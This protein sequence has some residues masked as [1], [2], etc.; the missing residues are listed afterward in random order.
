[1]PVDRKT[2]N[3]GILTKN[4]RRLTDRLYRIH[5]E[6][7][8]YAP[9]RDLTPLSVRPYRRLSLLSRRNGTPLRRLNADLQEHCKCGSSQIFVLNFAKGAVTVEFNWLIGSA[10]QLNPSAFSGGAKRV[11][12]TRVTK[13]ETSANICRNKDSNLFSRNHYISTQQKML[14]R[15]YI[16]A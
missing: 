1:M 16:K 11:N 15:F 4:F 6:P 3:R 14:L 12:P 7:N 13:N 8:G 10:L 2:T 5:R 9:D